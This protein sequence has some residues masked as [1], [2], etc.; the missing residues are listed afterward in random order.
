M[1]RKSPAVGEHVGPAS[2][3]FAL[4]IP[5]IVE[6]LLVARAWL[7]SEQVLL[8]SPRRCAPLTPFCKMFLL[9]AAALLAKIWH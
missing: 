5:L 4:E 1:K 8:V 2:N 3:L 9:V 6:N 7:F